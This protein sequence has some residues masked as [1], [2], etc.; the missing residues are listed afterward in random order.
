VDPGLV[1]CFVGGEFIQFETCGGDG[2][3]A[4]PSTSIVGI[5][6]NVRNISLLWLE[7]SKSWDTLLKR[8]RSAP[9]DDDAWARLLNKSKDQLIKQLWQR[10][11][12]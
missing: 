2:E 1:F 6:A 5:G 11:M 7:G 12:P 8:L 9:I 3:L 4:L 10:T